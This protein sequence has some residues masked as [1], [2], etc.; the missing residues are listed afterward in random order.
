MHQYAAVCYSLL[1]FVARAHVYG[2]SER[3]ELSRHHN[4]RNMD[5]VET[6]TAD[7]SVN[8]DGIAEQVNE[9]RIDEL[10]GEGAFAKVYKCEKQDATGSPQTFVRLLVM[11]LT[12]SRLT[13][14]RH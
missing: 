8:D 14:F 9:Y 10:L 7:V 12:L 13:Y 4:T 1:Q 3:T 5:V 6:N 2:R 11:F